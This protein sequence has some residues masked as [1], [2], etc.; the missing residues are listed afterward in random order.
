LNRKIRPNRKHGAPSFAQRRRVTG[1]TLKRLATRAV[2]SQFSLQF[3]AY[4][5]VT[6]T[7]LL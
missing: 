6:K 3:T 7:H 2:G 5:S 4:S 1:S